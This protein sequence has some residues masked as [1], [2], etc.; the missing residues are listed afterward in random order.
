MLSKGDIESD[1]A[2]SLSPLPCSAHLDEA[3][4]RK[5]AS[6][7]VEAIDRTG[8]K[9]D[10]DLALPQSPHQRPVHSK[11][12]PAP[13]FHC[14]SRRVRRELFEAYC[15]FVVAYREATKRLARGDPSPGFP[16]GSFPPSL[17]Y[18]AHA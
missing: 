4:Y 17:P 8:R 16:Q 15:W 1:E 12:S 7:P 11:R 3:T 10:L 6:E 18:V 13:Y 5:Y 14:A 9:N 2:F